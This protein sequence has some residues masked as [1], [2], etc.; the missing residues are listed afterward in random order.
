MQKKKRIAI[1][2]PIETHE[3]IKKRCDPYG[4]SMTQWVL[5]LIVKALEENQK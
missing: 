2:V 4:A 5:Q 3:K 1:E